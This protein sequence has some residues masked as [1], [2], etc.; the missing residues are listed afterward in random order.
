MEGKEKNEENV[1]DKEKGEE[2]IYRIT[3]RLPEKERQ[4]AEKLANY[5]YEYE[6]IKK[7][8]INEVVR[9]SIMYLGYVV[10]Q[11]AK[12]ETKGGDVNE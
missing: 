9:Y 2:K 4:L 8:S 10:A 11:Q 12:V 5:L 6:L 7:P 3:I 1:R